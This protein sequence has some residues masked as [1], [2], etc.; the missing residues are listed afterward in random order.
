VRADDVCQCN[1]VPK[2]LDITHLK[3]GLRDVIEL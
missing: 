2:I 1:L 3:G